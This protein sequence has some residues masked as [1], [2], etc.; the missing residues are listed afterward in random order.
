MASAA[1]P[2]P[3]DIRAQAQQQ[4]PPMPQSAMG[5]LGQSLE[6][7]SG[8]GPQDSPAGA[9]GKEVIQQLTQKVQQWET[10]TGEIYQMLGTVKPPLQALMGPVAQ[11]GN[12]LKQEIG[13]IA[14]T[15]GQAPG[16]PDR[17]DKPT[18]NPAEG[19]PRQVG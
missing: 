8:Q 6:Q 7:G 10:I 9:S 1:F 16:T 13:K 2:Q 15:F 4:E 12:A 3:P 19:M 18:P 17:S 5:A 14:Q 11:A